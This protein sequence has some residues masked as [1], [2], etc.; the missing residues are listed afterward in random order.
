MTCIAFMRA[1]ADKKCIFV[2]KMH[3]FPFA[4]FKF[5]KV[6]DLFTNKVD[7]YIIISVDKMSV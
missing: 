5:K 2:Q 6:H 7:K 4:T 1:K 3:I